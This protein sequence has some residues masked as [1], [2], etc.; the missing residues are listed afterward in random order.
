MLIMAQ[1]LLV[2]K[3]EQL[4]RAVELFHKFVEDLLI[5]KPVVGLASYTQY[6]CINKRFHEVTDD[7][8][9]MQY[10][11][12]ELQKHNR[13][14]YRY[15]LTELDRE[16]IRRLLIQAGLKVD[17]RLKANSKELNYFINSNLD[18]VTKMRKQLI[19][20]Y[21]Q[22]ILNGFKRERGFRQEECLMKVLANPSI[23]MIDAGICLLTH[24][25]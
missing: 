24:Q 9:N 20:D 3:E 5:V 19:K 18:L 12:R 11:E 7:V 22:D 23:T 13:I 16:W 1:V 8:G 14:I 4:N 17:S 25:S 2:N 6:I 21:M 10:N 15:R